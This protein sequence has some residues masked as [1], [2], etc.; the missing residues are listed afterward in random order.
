[1]QLT[2]ASDSDPTPIRLLAVVEAEST[3]SWLDLLLQDCVGVEFEIIRVGS[4]E[5]GL[6]VIRDGACHLAL[7]DLA[8]EAEGDALTWAGVAVAQVPIIVLADKDDEADELRALRIGV[9]DY[10]TKTRATPETLVRSIRHAVERH[11]LLTELRDARQR[12]HFVATHDSLTKLLNRSSFNEQLDRALSY[13]KRH[14]KRLAVIFLDFDGFKYINDTLGHTIGDQL[15]T[16]ASE[17]L[18]AEIRQSDLVARVGGDEF[19]A[20]IQD[21]DRDQTAALVA[22]KLLES[23]SM[24]YTLSD[25]EYWVTA[26][27]G[28]SIYPRDGEDRET[29][30][31]HAD[32]AMYQAKDQGK[33]NYQFYSQSLNDATRKRLNLER[34]LRRAFE[35]GQ[36]ELHYQPKVDLKTNQIT[37]AEALLR[38]NDPDLGPVSPGEFIGVAEETGFIR[39]LGDWVLRT[40]CEEAK[41]WQDQGFD[42]TVSVNVSTHQIRAEVLRESIVRVLWDSGLKPERLALEITEST[43][44]ENPDEA[45]IALQELKQIGISISLDDFGTGFSSLSYLKRI[46]V[47]TVKIDQSFIGDIVHDQDDAAIVDAILSIAEKLRLKVIAEGVETEAQRRFLASRNCQEMQGYLFSPAVPAEAFVQLLRA[48]QGTERKEP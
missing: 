47:D 27:L 35:R 13:A 17:R 21:L 29:L 6:S 5:E 16:Q 22:Q 26:S 28:I 15:L 37:G 45:V 31:R 34:N 39:P 38:W 23:I 30:V 7:V 12:E 41:S 9:Q 14:N 20:M 1:M 2:T 36:L 42:A 48:S 8:A 19:I 33:N 46:P 43:L 18:A 32:A 40:A 11:R 25:R 3:N 44:M 24:P 4:F 10:I